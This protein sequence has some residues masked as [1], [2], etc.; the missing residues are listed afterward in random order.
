MVPSDVL[1]GS[2][3]IGVAAPQGRQPLATRTTAPPEMNE[4]IYDADMAVPIAK[5]TGTAAVPAQFKYAV[6]QQRRVKVRTGGSDNAERDS[7]EAIETIKKLEGDIIVEADYEVLAGSMSAFAGR[8]SL[9]GGFVAR[10]DGQRLTV[11]ERNGKPFEGLVSEEATMLAGAQVGMKRA[12]LTWLATLPLRVGD[13]HQLTAADWKAL[14]ADGANPEGYV[15][16]L[17]DRADRLVWKILMLPPPTQHE[18]V[19]HYEMLE[20][21]ARTGFVYRVNTV[22]VITSR[23]GD[24]LLL[25]TSTAVIEYSQD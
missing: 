10:H 19:R 21:D 4:T 7:Y 22:S 17:P 18:T 15:T 24:K 9:S 6:G 11:T 12:E 16:R 8:S 25:R 5:P 23:D 20:V 3:S 13:V 2:S 1:G 14:E